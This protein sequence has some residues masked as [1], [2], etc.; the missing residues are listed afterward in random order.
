MKKHEIRLRDV[1]PE[2]VEQLEQISRVRNFRTHTKTIQFLI[3]DYSRTEQ[4][5]EILKKDL[6]KAQREISKLTQ[7]KDSFKDIVEDLN[8]TL[9]TTQ[10]ECKRILKQT[11]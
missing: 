1:D 7:L 10:I 3:T 11:K 2:L 9:S 5:M 8:L 4:Q 6:A